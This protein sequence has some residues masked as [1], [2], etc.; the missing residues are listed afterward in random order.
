LM[1]VYD[2]D[3]LREIGKVFA[4]TTNDSRAE[5]D[6]RLA[7][8]ERPIAEVRYLYATDDEQLYQPVFIR[9]RDDKLAIECLR[10]Q[11]EKTRRDV[12]EH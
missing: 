11:L 8:G 10:S 2:G 1:A 9:L 5:L 4:G 3:E 7:A 6:E 12:H